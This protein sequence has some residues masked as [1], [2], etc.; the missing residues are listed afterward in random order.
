MAVHLKALRVS[1]TICSQEPYRFLAIRGSEALI[2]EAAGGTADQLLHCAAD[3]V[4]PLRKVG[5]VLGRESDLSTTIKLAIC[6]AA[7]GTAD[8]LLHCAADCVPPLRKV[9]TVLGRE[10]DLSTTIK[11]AI[12]E[13]AGGTADQALQCFANCIP[14][15]LKVVMG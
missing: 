7:G 1:C 2:C 12:C 14:L 11:L 9:G 6:E 3:C 8:L 5:A 13:A 4:P 10:S 15:H